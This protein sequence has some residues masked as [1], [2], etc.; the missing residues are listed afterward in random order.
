MLEIPP[1]SLEQHDFKSN[2]NAILN[3]KL[4]PENINRYAD[5]ALDDL[6]E[7]VD[8]VLLSFHQEP[9]VTSETDRDNEQAAFTYYGLNPDTIEET[10]D[11]VAAIADEIHEL[12]TLLQQATEHSE[13]VILPPG[14]EERTVITP[15]EGTFKER[16]TVE[17]TKTVSFILKNRF[18]VDLRNPEEFRMTSGVLSDSM[19]R[20]QGY[21]MIEVP[22]LDRVIFVCDEEGNATFIFDTA[23]LRD[24]I[25]NEE[26]AG[27]TK[28]EL[29]GLIERHQ[30]VGRRLVY[31]RQFVEQVVSL[32][33]EIPKSAEEEEQIDEES[34]RFLRIS[35]KVS[36]DY[37]AV[38]KIADKFG[39]AARTV[40][41]AITDM[42]KLLSPIVTK[43]RNTY[44]SLYSPEDQEK[45]YEY[46]DNRGTFAPAATKDQLSV[47]GMARE[48]GVTRSAIDK[49]IG[50]LGEALGEVKKAKFN[51]SISFAYSP[52]QQ[53]LIKERLPDNET[54]GLS[55]VQLAEKLS[56]TR[57]I[58]RK[59]RYELGD[60]Q[61]LTSL[62]D[63][64]KR[65]VIPSSQ[66]ELIGQ[67]VEEYKNREKQA[68]TTAPEGYESRMDMVRRLGVH[69]RTVSR[70]IAATKGQLGEVQIALFSNNPSPAYSPEQQKIIETWLNEN[71]RRQKN[72]KLGKVGV[73]YA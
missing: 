37:L 71:I 64:G 14:E 41:M 27:R 13:K 45:I 28:D 8:S 33:E 53:R 3:R 66:H 46:L 25:T 20:G 1:S 62:V 54:D 10:L 2:I 23:R 18:D 56:T 16:Q 38:N 30:S 9:V 70:A 42:G 52:E 65:V 69:H 4:T 5:D 24:R 68:T 40:S 29:Y 63:D 19:M 48:F 17:R 59:I 49:A 72:S 15:G 32:L 7:T 22:A 21:S 44:A 47:F 73:K 60:E 51:A 36:D 67:K 39:V 61:V 43:K 50:E 26:L 34:G 58:I 6:I 55:E 57:H 12:D 31:S 35:E 11:H